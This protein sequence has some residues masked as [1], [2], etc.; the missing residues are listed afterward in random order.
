MLCAPSQVGGD[1][2]EDVMLFLL[3][4][5]VVSLVVSLPRPSLCSNFGREDESRCRVFTAAQDSRWIDLSK[6]DCRNSG[7]ALQG[8]AVM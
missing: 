1:L 2:A 3:S 5:D 7:N 4:G 8:A 6:N